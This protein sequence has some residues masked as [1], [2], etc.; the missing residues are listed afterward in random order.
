MFFSKSFI[1]DVRL[2][3]E[4]A[5]GPVTAVAKSCILNF[6]KGSEYASALLSL[7]ILKWN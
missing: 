6:W 4:Y 5:S 1:L 3:S 2:R 7:A